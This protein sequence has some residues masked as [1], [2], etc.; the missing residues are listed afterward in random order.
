MTLHRSTAPYA[1]HCPVRD[2]L[3]RLGDRWST[4]VLQALKDAPLRFA[5]LQRAIDD[6]SKRMLA[7]T[8]R[9]LEEDGLIT[10]TVYPSKPPAVEYALTPLGRSFVPQIEALVAWAEIHHDAIRSARR[11]YR[12]QLE[13]AV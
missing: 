5:A 10:R 9:G 4:L 6:V 3:D 7:K 12:E 8:L 1:D 13:A 2:V 11:L